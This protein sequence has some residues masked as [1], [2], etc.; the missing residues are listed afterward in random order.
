[1]KNTYVNNDTYQT[2]TDLKVGPEPFEKSITPLWKGSPQ[3][4]LKLKLNGEEKVLK[5]KQLMKRG[6]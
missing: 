2:L 1:M 3:D 5:K 6:M 4:K